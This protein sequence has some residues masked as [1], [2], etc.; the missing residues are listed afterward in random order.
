MFEY[1]PGLAIYF[2]DGWY[3]ASVYIGDYGESSGGD[4]DFYGL[5]VLG[6]GCFGV[7]EKTWKLVYKN[8]D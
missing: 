5:E 1:A 6:S 2:E 4:P 7:F 3:S 8:H